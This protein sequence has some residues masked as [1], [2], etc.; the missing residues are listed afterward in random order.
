MSRY[1][2]LVNYLLLQTI[3]VVNGPDMANA[4]IV[5]AA[6]ISIYIYLVRKLTISIA[7]SI[8]YNI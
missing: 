5:T 4:A 1:L 3:S 7:A 8:K 6:N 2:Y